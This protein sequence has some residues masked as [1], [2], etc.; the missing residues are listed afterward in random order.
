MLGMM[1][2]ALTGRL[3]IERAVRLISTNGA[4]RFGIYPRKGVIA[5]GSDADLV[6]FDPRATTTI[7][8]DM[9]FSKARACDK[10]YE[11]T[12]FQGKIRRTLVNG[13]T[14]FLDNTITG[15]PGWGQFVRPDPDQIHQEV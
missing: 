4:K 15:E 6:V 12:T 2:A 9:L 13:R 7:H 8:T 1:N 5:V 3:S 11:G 14:V 10:L